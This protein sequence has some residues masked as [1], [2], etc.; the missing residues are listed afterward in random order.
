MR[1]LE[2]LFYIVFSTCCFSSANAYDLV[3]RLIVEET[4]AKIPQYKE[5]SACT[6]QYQYLTGAEENKNDTTYIL[7]GLPDKGIFVAF[8]ID[9][10][11]F[12]EAVNS[13]TDTITIAIPLAMLPRSVNLAE[14]SV[15][16]DRCYLTD[17]KEVYRP[18]ARDKRISRNA[19]LLL[20]YMAIPSI[21]I[22]PVDNNITM[23][24]GE[25]VSMFIDYLP[26]TKMSLN[27]LNTNDVVRVE[28]YENP[29]DPRF[30]GVRYAVNFVMVK[31][32]YGG[33]T[34]FDAEQRFIMNRGRYNAYSKMKYK[35]MTYDA[36]V[37]ANYL[38]THNQYTNDVEQY[39]FGDEII[40]YAKE[41]QRARTANHDITS[42]FKALFQNENTTVDNTVGII[43]NN[44]PG[45]YDDFTESF[46]SPVYQ[47][48]SHSTATYS[49]SFGVSW[50]GDYMF[51]LP[52]KYYLNIQPRV[53]YTKFDS[54]YD[55]QSGNVNINNDNTDKAWITD[56]DMRLSRYFSQHY[57]S[58]DL[59]GD[60]NGNDMT[61]SGTTPEDVKSREYQAGTKLRAS[62]KFGKVN[63]TA[64]FSYLYKWKRVG[65]IFIRRSLPQYYF[66][67]SYT[68]NNR[69]RLSFSSLYEYG[70]IPVSEL[71]PNLQIQ[72]Q[73]MAKTGNPWLKTMRAIDNNFS[74]YLRLS[75]NITLMPT[76]RYFH[77]ERCVAYDYRPIEIN[78]RSIMLR[79]IDNT[80][81]SNDWSISVPVSYQTSDYSLSLRVEPKLYAMND[82][83][84]MG[85][86]KTFMRF[87]GSLSYSIG[88]FYLSTVYQTRGYS[89]NRDEHTYYRQYYYFT[90]GWSN[91]R[92][93]LSASAYCPFTSSY[94][95]GHTNYISTYYNSKALDFSP[96]YRRSFGLT[97]TYTFSYGKKVE[98]DQV[99]APAAMESG[100]LK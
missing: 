84:I 6:Q 38:N 87:N 4:K 51:N 91:G 60:A 74:Y 35:K 5:L 32:E 48:G 77:A 99:E 36:A 17:Q 81:V 94:V 10:N 73:I 9:E 12:T 39:Q 41:T 70:N 86:K 7:K 15:T 44:A 75:S 49:S 45:G 79:T 63:F 22:N 69:N 83:G 29:T 93:N 46:S 90:L 71:A 23:A 52:S 59:T 8:K 92:L 56:L 13:P 72:N 89:I 18:S 57:F 98:H 31:Y 14:V 27:N 42:F 16:A 100:L 80:G 85:I 55:Y 62:L 26:A 47:S 25:A 43:Y 3:V 37:S 96:S 67:T 78:G 34:K 53:S 54:R 88:D 97:A 65:S 64:Y 58:L 1:K 50:N 19:A 21:S 33:F 24:A 28:V 95:R 82:K 30:R 11:L 20:Q 66:S 68:L 61:Y 40:S 2:I 76:V